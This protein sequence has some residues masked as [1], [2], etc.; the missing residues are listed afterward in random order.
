MRRDGFILGGMEMVEYLDIRCYGDVSSYCVA[1]IIIS[2][3]AG[4][5]DP[6]YILDFAGYISRLSGDFI[7]RWIFTDR[8]S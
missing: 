6:Y 5:R 4:V 1:Y 3:D 2:S 8:F 7:G